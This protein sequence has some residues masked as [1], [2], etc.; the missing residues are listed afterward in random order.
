MSVRTWRSSSFL[1]L[2]TYDFQSN[3]RAS[4]K[5]GALANYDKQFYGIFVYYDKHCILQ[6]EL[7]P[8]LKWFT[9]FVIEDFKTGS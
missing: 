8:V 9:K 4:A 3:N 6:Y 1:I 7:E 2:T 5:V